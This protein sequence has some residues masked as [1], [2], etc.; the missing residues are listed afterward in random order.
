MLQT[1]L[2]RVDEFLQ[3]RGDE[4]LARHE[5]VCQ[6]H[7]KGQIESCSVLVLARQTQ[8]LLLVAKGTTA[9]RTLFRD[10]RPVN[11]I[12]F[13][14]LQHLQQIGM[15][16]DRQTTPVP[17]GLWEDDQCLITLQ[18][19]LPGRPL[20]NIP[21]RQIFSAG[22]LSSSIG[23]VMTW[24]T[25]FQH[26]FG[27]RRTPM[28]EAFYR[29][30]VLLPLDAFKR[31][32]TLDDQE[33]QLLADRFEDRSSLLDLELPLFVR[34]GDFCPANMMFEPAGIGVFDW[35]FPLHG[36]LSPLDLFH[37]FGSTRFPFKGMQGESGHFESFVEVYWGNSYFSRTMRR[38]LADVCAAFEIPLRV[39]PDLFLLSLIDI[40][41]LKYD[42]LI[43]Y[44]MAEGSQEGRDEE[45]SVLWGTAGG[46]DKDAPFACI[47]DGVSMNLRHT[48]RNGLP[49]FV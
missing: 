36:Y 34:H 38:C 8:E 11:R 20:L 1:I 2:K 30:A 18:A 17:L 33:R 31:H 37:F 22:A 16:R 43:D 45:R 5:Y 3:E 12:E 48:A 29:D 49:A 41:N 24:W 42:A 44:D 9:G 14:N 7:S 21:A 47:R 19:A 10:G 15:N 32:F 6:D 39:L 28:T 40:A 23:H 25:S 4:G 13:E 27:V 35:E 26:N 46:V